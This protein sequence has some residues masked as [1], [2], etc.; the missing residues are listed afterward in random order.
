MKKFKVGKYYIFNKNGKKINKAKIHALVEIDD[1]L[2]AVFI[3]Y[4]DV[5]KHVHTLP[6]EIEGETQ[7][8][9]FNDAGWY[10]SAD[11]PVQPKIVKF[12]VG[13]VYIDDRCDLYQLTNRYTDANGNT[14][15]V[16]DNK[17]IGE[18]FK[19][20]IDGKVVERTCFSNYEKEVASKVIAN[21]NIWRLKND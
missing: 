9:H 11:S 6:I 15:I 3:Y 1:I 7:T 2:H 8:I 18:V 13:K 14:Y 21:N 19:D 17:F 20:K 10:L 12:K 4:T 5:T 16:L